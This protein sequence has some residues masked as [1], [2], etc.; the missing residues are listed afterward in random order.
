MDAFCV[1]QS[2]QEAT[3]N[4]FQTPTCEWLYHKSQQDL[5]PFAEGRYTYNTGDELPTPCLA[6]Q[7]N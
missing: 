5:L 1:N 3:I 2:G 4:T 7:V 6:Y